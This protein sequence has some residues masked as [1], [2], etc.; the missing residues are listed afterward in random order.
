[1]TWPL[2]FSLPHPRTLTAAVL[3]LALALAC[4]EEPKVPQVPTAAPRLV[5]GTALAVTVVVPAGLPAGVQRAAEDLNTVLAARSGMPARPVVATVAAAATPVVVAVEVQA[6]TALGTEGYKLVQHAWT[7]DKHGLRI[8]A[9][10]WQGAMYGLTDVAHRLGARWH[11]PEEAFMPPADPTATLPWTVDGTAQTPRFALRGLHEHTQH[12]IPASDWYLRPS[13]A[14]KQYAF[15][16]FRWLA[17]NRANVASFHLLKTVDLQKWTPYA[18]ELAQ[19]AKTYGVHLGAVTSF[20]DEQQNNYKHIE[21]SKKTPDDVQIRASLDALAATGLGFIVF[22]IG[23][24]EFTKPSDAKVLGWLDTAAAHLADKHPSV[25]PW[26]WIHTTCGLHADDG[27][28]FYHLPQKTNAKLGFWVH[29]TMFYDLDHPA[30][31]YGCKDFHAQR[32]FLDASLGKRPVGYFPETAW[33]LG[34]DVNLPLALPITGWSRAHDIT[35]VLAGTKVESHVTFTTG[36]E[37]GYW[38]YDHYVLRAAW[39]GKLGWSAYLHDI[40]PLF[41]SQGAKV[42]E[43]LNQ[44]SLLQKKHLYDTDP[45]WIFYLAGEL[46]Q[47]EIGEAAGILARRPKPAFHKV[48]ALPDAEWQKWLKQYEALIATEPQYQALLDQLPL[49]SSATRPVETKLLAETR[50]VL[51]LYVHRLRHVRELYA[52]VVAMRPWQQ[53]VLA[54][55]PGKEPPQSVKDAAMKDAEAHIQAAKAIAADVL[56]VLSAAEARYRYP[57]EMLARKKP[58]TLTAYPFGYLEQT[59]SGHFWTRRDGQIQALFAKTFGTAKDAWPGAAPKFAYKMSGQGME[60]LQPKSKVAE[61]VLGGFMP[62]FAVG[63]DEQGG[64]LGL[65]LGQDQNANGLPDGGVVQDVTLQPQDGG[66]GGTKDVFALDVVDSAGTSLG[67]LALLGAAFLAE[68]KGAGSLTHLRL[69]GKTSAAAFLAMMQQVGGID[70]AGAEAL[71]ASVF[72]LPAGEPLPA[73]LNVEFRFGL[74]AK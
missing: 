29:T 37:W 27:S 50:A 16:Y 21:A 1:V 53:A 10:A 54:A 51:G 56:Q 49:P 32:G 33:W 5:S 20:A 14:H 72:G 74:A 65:R 9:G 48:L 7:A 19:E 69:G 3:A 22:Q 43:V 39:D 31:V 61:G 38:Q 47:D 30:P 46:A 63:V 25:H 70:R 17:R 55:G 42:A 73:Q 52:A 57:V 2:G 13:A 26:V 12:P 71:V 66:F 67:T 40:A 35:T 45:E 18:Q 36:R 8:V 11:H 62:P 34:F 24:S 64:G 41:G 68:G 28:P 59:S 4:G 44:W 23:T 58:E 6:A 60:L 15:H